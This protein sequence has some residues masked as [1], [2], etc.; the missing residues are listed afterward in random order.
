MRVY[1]AYLD[2]MESQN[3]NR[4]IREMT[5]DEFMYIYRKVTE[6]DAAMYHNDPEERRKFL[7]ECMDEA[8]HTWESRVHAY[9]ID[10]RQGLVT[11]KNKDGSSYIYLGY[12]PEEDRGPKSAR[13][14]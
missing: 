10:G 9:T 12:V 7:E 4:T 13:C 1:L 3:V 14:S 5:L 6:N 2:C 11:V 8:W